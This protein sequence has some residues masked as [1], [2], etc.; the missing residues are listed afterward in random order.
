[1]RLYALPIARQPTSILR[2]GSSNSPVASQLVYYYARMPKKSKLGADGQPEQPSLLQKGVD[3]T[4]KTW[5]AW[6]KAE[7]G[8]KLKVHNWGESV[9]ERID[10]E[11]LALKAIDPTLGPKLKRNS[12]SSHAVSAELKKAVESGQGVTI[13]LY[14]SPSA[15]P[16]P[17][18]HLKNLLS[19]RKPNHRKWMMIWIAVSPLTA[20]FAIVPIVPNIPF[21]FC[22]WRAWSHWRAYRGAKFLTELVEHRAL[23]PTPHVGLEE[24]YSSVAS[25][26]SQA[27]PP[28]P[29]PTATGPKSSGDAVVPSKSIP[30]EPF[31]LSRPLIPDLLSAIQQEPALPSSPAAPADAPQQDMKKLSGLEPELARAVDQVSLR[32]SSST[33][34]H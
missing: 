7:G 25:R 32:L 8:W 4:A 31:L 19:E 14:H 2:T 16:D 10:F 17:L 24:F 5:T 15:L 12:E 34:S 30:P 1:M 20:P 3:F 26:Q 13:P 27:S 11:E 21:F 6:G 23:V 9:Y 33:T 28:P 22:I 18:A 29:S